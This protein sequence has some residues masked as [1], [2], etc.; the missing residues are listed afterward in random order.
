MG[1]M[2]AQ[3]RARLNLFQR[4]ASIDRASRPDKPEG[5]V[6][7]VPTPRGFSYRLACLAG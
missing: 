1:P 4:G 6:G 3:K 5:F 7:G 2:N